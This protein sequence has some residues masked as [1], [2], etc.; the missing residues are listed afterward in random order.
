MRKRILVATLV[1]TVLGLVLFSLATT[2][3]SYRTLIE[4]TEAVLTVQVNSLNLDAYTDD[5]AA[6]SPS[7]IRWTEC[8]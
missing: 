4:N 1:I 3:V 6:P 7:P 2:T 8:A 5:P